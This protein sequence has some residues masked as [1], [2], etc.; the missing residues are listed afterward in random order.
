[1]AGPRRHLLLYLD[2]EGE[3]QDNTHV[4]SRLRGWKGPSTARGVVH[5][6]PPRACL[7]MRLH[8][9]L[10]YTPAYSMWLRAVQGHPINRLFRLSQ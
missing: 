1:M 6:P 8:T 7:S 3:N 9:I 4:D 5:A 2:T 10:Y